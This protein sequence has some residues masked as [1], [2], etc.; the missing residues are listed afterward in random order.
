MYTID[1]SVWVNAFDEREPGHEVSRSFLAE[2]H[3]HLLPIVVPNLVCV[4][5]AA[6]ISRTRSDPDRAQEF[7][8]ALGSLPNATLVTLTDEL[9][10][11][12]IDLASR[13]GLRGADAVYAAV[14]LRTECTLVSLDREHLSRLSQVVRVDA[15]ADALVDIRK[16]SRQ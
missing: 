8:A 5:V 12:A 1:A 13:N 15:P 9:A 14:A 7:A 3:S 4:E 11:E 2:V 6:A 16:S 10:F